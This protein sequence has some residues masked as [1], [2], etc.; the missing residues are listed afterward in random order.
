M[1]F[2]L[3][4]DHTNPQEH[5][6][7][8]TL[9]PLERNAD[10]SEESSGNTNIGRN[11]LQIN[12]LDRFDGGYYRCEVEDNAGNKN[13]ESYFITTLEKGKSLIEIREPND[14][15]LLNISSKDKTNAVWMVEYNGH[16]KPELV[17]YDNNNN[18]IINNLFD[19]RKKYEVTIN[20]GHTTLKIFQVELKDMGNYT[21]K[22]FNEVGETKEK[23]FELIVR[24]KSTFFVVV[25]S[26]GAK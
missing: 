22:A 3:I 23:Q 25:N 12:D 18:Q 8:E 15:Y 4:D 9:L 7:N 26:V 19:K 5:R 20:E 6:T 10:E 14:L 11:S 13:S 16:P 2:T 21:L 17:W 24:G 1:L